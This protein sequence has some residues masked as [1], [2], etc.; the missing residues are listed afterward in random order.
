MYKEYYIYQTTFT[1]LAAGNGTV[2]T[3]NEIRI[4]SDSEFILQMLVQE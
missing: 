3:D 1:S 2:F 4:D